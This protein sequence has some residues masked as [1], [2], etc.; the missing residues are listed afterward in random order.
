MNIF[1]IEQNY[2]GHKR[3]QR[4]EIPGEPVIF[5]KPQSALLQTAIPF[6]Y[7]K[8]ANELYCGC[9][10]VLRISKNGKDIKEKLGRQLL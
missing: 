9:E 2:F 3:E 1:C 6:S 10:L 7:P 5:V 4:N 8:R